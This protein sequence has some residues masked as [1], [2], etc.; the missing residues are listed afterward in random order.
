VTRRAAAP[1]TGRRGRRAASRAAARPGA[2]GLL[3]IPLFL[4]VYLGVTIAW[5]APGWLALVYLAASAVCFVV[6]VADKSAARAGRWRVSERV[7]LGLGLV[8][9][10]PGALV[11]QQVVRHKSRK[12]AFQVAFWI[13]VLLN[14]ALLVALTAPWSW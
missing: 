4:I 2:F 11:A 13:S 8:G 10:W 14:L 9:G 5:R 6:Y 1:R 7:L 12:T 3:A